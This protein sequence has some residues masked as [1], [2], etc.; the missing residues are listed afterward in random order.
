MM[1]KMHTY[2]LSARGVADMAKKHENVR[3]R[4]CADI[5]KPLILNKRTLR[6]H[7]DSPKNVRDRFWGAR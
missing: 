4:T 5:C 6:G 3:A 1:H 2:R 7:L